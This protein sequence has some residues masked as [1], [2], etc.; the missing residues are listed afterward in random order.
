MINA[1]TVVLFAAALIFTAPSARAEQTILA[2][3]DSLTAGYGLSKAD[4]FPAKL[5]AALNAVGRDVRVVNGGVSGDTSKGGLS[6]VDWLFADKPDVL[7]IELGAN[8]G[9][10][11][12]PP[13]DTEKNLAAIIEKGIAADAT[14][15]LTGMLAPPNLGR[16][17]GAAFNAVFPRLAERYDVAF[18]PFFLDGVVA[19]PTLNLGD[20]MH[21]NP[22]GVD[23]IVERILPSVLDALDAAEADAATGT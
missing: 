9:L 6:R 15:L 23:V 1:A 4:S 12:L 20:G 19:E 13:E 17:Y 8:D 7:L 11:G 18:Y 14:V 16:D 5:Q 2:L 21:P 3:G 22:A 10:R